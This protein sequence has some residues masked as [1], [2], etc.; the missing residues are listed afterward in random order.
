[1]KVYFK[2][3]WFSPRGTRY[4]KGRSYLIPDEWETFLPAT[5]EV[6]DEEEPAEAIEQELIQPTPRRARK[7]AEPAKVKL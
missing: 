3:A 1:M 7:K 4:R 2:N 6:L 5:A